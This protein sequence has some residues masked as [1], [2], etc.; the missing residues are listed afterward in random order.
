MKRIIKA[1]VLALLIA[2][3]F[4]VGHSQV[5][6]A[7]VS[8][9]NV[10]KAIQY[11]W[12]HWDDKTAYDGG[13]LD[14]V[15]F[16]RACVEAGG[17]P[18]EAGR[19]GGY[20]P[21]Q[22]VNYIKNSGFAAFYKLT[23]TPHTWN[24][25][26][27][28]VDTANVNNV[29]KISTGDIL[30]YHCT[31]D[32]CSKPYFHLEVVGSVDL[33]SATSYAHNTAKCDEAVITFPHSA[34]KSKGATDKDT[35]ILVLHFKSAANGYT[36][37]TGVSAKR[38]SYNSIKVSWT[39]KM[40]ADGYKVYRKTSKNGI[41]KL[42]IDTKNTSVTNKIATIGNT[43]YY[44]VAPYNVLEL[45]GVS[46]TIP[47]YYSTT[48]SAKTYL[49]KP[50]GVEVVKVASGKLKVSWSKMSGATGYQIYRATSK[51][52]KYTKILT[53]KK[54]TCTDTKRVKGKTYYYKI[55]SYNVSNGKTAY[56]SFSTPVGKKMK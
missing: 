55:R 49:A 47:G 24:S 37:V 12:E 56:S 15:K 30:V 19:T 8:S 5:Y 21:L 43:Y 34:C 36:K 6:A 42:L 32:G 29:G 3:F 4:T 35:E 27:Y 11:A 13:K 26:R 46:K 18:K 2:I 48:V 50:V 1:S 14:C 52:G 54:T 20:T 23:L 7:D 39:D 53:T 9:Y 45:G 33:G 25:N 38:A 31:K 51:S 22:Y 41:W 28:Y 10:D 16:T 17:V 44:R 40:N